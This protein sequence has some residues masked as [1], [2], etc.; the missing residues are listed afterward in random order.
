MSGGGKQSGGMDSGKMGGREWSPGT[1]SS[2][3]SYTTGISKA[4]IWIGLWRS[5]VMAGSDGIFVYRMV[6]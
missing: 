6:L 3:A 4:E 2:I 5:P 1:L